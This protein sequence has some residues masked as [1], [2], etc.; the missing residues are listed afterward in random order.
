VI[1]VDT[2]VWIAANRAPRGEEATT[3]RGLLDHDEVA[4][5]LPVR[6]ELLAGAAQRDRT[7]LRRA[8]TGLPLLVPTDDTW[9]CV[10][11]WIGPAADAGH[12]FGLADLL[13][14]ALSA[15]LGALVW[16]HDADFDQMETLGFVRRCR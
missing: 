4:L 12:H 11:R 3:L 8:L 5:A 7:P 1:V 6:I 14:A 13:I 16:S 2:S 10:E 9:T 15:D